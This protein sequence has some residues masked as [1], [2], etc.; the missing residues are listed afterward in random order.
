MSSTAISTRMGRRHPWALLWRLM[1]SIRT[2]VVLSIQQ[3]CRVVVLKL[4]SA[5]IGEVWGLKIGGYVN[6]LSKLRLQGSCVRSE[7]EAD[8]ALFFLPT[9]FFYDRNNRNEE[10][11]HTHCHGSRSYYA[12]VKILHV[13]KQTLS[14]FKIHTAI[15]PRK[16]LQH[17]V[18]RG[19]DCPIARY[20]SRRTVN[21]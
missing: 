11:L 13:H 9:R 4:L 18:A 19:E 15:A 7:A 16:T 14:T 17:T 5:S 6:S 12:N 3:I 8:F 10:P 1:F 21:C 20:K 2:T